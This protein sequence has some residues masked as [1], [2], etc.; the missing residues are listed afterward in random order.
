MDGIQPLLDHVG[1]TV[2]WDAGLPLHESKRDAIFYCDAGNH[3][4]VGRVKISEFAVDIYCDGITD[5]RDRT[6]GERY[7]CGSDL[8]N[9]GWDTDEKLNEGTESSDLDVVNNSWFDLYCDGEH[10]DAVSHDVWDAIRDAISW[11][12][13]EKQNAQAIENVGVDF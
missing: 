4:F 7:S 2:E 6:N 1:A 12:Q 9:A 11:L 3:N 5:I 13:N 8:I 10:L